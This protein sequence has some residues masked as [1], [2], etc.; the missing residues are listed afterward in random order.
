ML[1][2]LGPDAADPIEEFLRLALDHGRS[3]APSL[4]G[5]LAWLEAGSIEVNAISTRN[6]TSLGPPARCAS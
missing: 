3:H 2:R 1:A 5:F 4:Q 6:R